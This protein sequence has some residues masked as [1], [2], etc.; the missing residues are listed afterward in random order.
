MCARFRSIKDYKQ[1]P[2]RQ[3]DWPLLN[4][5]F[6][7]NVAPTEEVPII[8]TN[9]DLITLTKGRF[10]LLKNYGGKSRQILNARTDSIR[11]G[12]F[13]SLVENKRCIIPA[14]GFYEW[15]EENGK[16]PYIFERADGQPIFFVGIWDTCE[17]KGEKGPCFAILTD[18]PN[19]LVA[20]YHDR[21]PLIVDD[22]KPW[23]D[24]RPLQELKALGA[25]DFSVRPVNRA[26]NNPRTKDISLIEA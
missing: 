11:N 19:E 6:N 13:K 23:L 24:G 4:F 12:S 20:A 14:S 5:E 3:P 7:P 8:I 22:P 2:L 1:I 26:L 18:E 10:G 17:I 21:M 9:G 16:Q 25:N 15:R